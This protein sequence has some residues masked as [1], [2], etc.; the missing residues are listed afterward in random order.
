[1]KHLIKTQRQ[2]QCD[3]LLSESI[4]QLREEIGAIFEK[5]R[6]IMKYQGYFI[7]PN[8]PQPAKGGTSAK[9]NGKASGTSPRLRQVKWG[10]RRSGSP[11]KCG[12]GRVKARRVTKS[13]SPSLSL[14]M[15]GRK[16]SAWGKAGRDSAFSTGADVITLIIFYGCPQVFAE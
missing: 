3:S 9:T 2:E 16:S 10:P 11:L 13:R 14:R 5:M 15:T 8:T 4:E 7:T 6:Y 12:R 1:M